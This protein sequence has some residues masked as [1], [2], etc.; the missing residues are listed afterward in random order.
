MKIGVIGIGKLGLSF[1]LLAENKGFEVIGSD[2]NQ[3][4]IDSFNNRTYKTD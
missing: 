1:S 4:Y 2:F 3:S